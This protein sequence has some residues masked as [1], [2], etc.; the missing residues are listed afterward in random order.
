[1]SLLNIF[2]TEDG[3]PEFPFLD[4]RGLR[5]SRLGPLTPQVPHT[6]RNEVP[7]SLSFPSYNCDP[8]DA[9]VAGDVLG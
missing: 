5:L 9:T 3:Q 7:L 8:T 4:W 6:E 2:P 1:M